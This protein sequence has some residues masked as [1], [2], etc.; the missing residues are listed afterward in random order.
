MTW[1][2]SDERSAMKEKDEVN[3]VEDHPISMN[4]LT[5]TKERGA[6]GR[7]SPISSSTRPQ[8]AEPDGAQG[9]GRGPGHD[10]SYGGAAGSGL[11]PDE[12]P[13]IALA[14]EKLIDETVG[15]PVKE[16]IVSDKKSTSRNN[17]G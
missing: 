1:K 4:W 16:A 2:S 5:R 17:D 12:V 13:A 9:D 15:A 3:P 7:W 14:F 11:R 6:Y 8:V 10:S